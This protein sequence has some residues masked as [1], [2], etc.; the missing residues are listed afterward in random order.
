MRHY[1]TSLNLLVPSGPVQAC[2]GIA[3]PFYR[4]VERCIS[5]DSN[6]RQTR[7]EEFR[8]YHREYAHEM[9]RVWCLNGREA[10]FFFIFRVD[11][12]AGRLGDTSFSVRRTDV[13][14]T[15]KSVADGS[16]E[17]LIIF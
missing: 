13:S 2:N 6:I 15:L 17:M 4:A 16:S 3:L 9:H 8:S 11:G 1:A 10:V 5:E 12:Y 7:P 14:F